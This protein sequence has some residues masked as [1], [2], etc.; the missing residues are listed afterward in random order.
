MNSNCRLKSER[1][2][3]AAFISFSAGLL[4]AVALCGAISPRSL[5][6]EELELRPVDRVA[7]ARQASGKKEGGGVLG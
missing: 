1:P 4:A 6:Q 3:K 7:R 2:D 5:A